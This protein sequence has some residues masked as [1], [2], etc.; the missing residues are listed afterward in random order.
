MSLKKASQIKSSDPVLPGVPILLGVTGSIAAYKAADL[1][2]R[3]VQA[4]A[5]VRTVLTAAGTEFI[6]PLTF[7]ALTGNL[8]Y[9]EMFGD[10]RLCD[11]VHIS[12]ARFPELVVIAPASADFIGRLA[13]GL[14][15][16]LLSA[17]VMATRAPVLL[18]PGMNSRMYENPIVQENIQRLQKY[19]MELVGP[20]SGYLACGERGSGRLAS[21]ENIFAAITARLS[22]P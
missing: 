13:A 12:L 11:P 22:H 7:Q 19:G 21:V 9:T 15:D 10:Q 3:L 16:D 18:A 8:V 6:T 4:G 17:I 1:A 2:S 5:E 14:A 20:E